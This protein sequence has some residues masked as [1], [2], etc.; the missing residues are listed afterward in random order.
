L[1]FDRLSELSLHLFASQKR[2]GLSLLIHFG[3]GRSVFENPWIKDFEIRAFFSILAGLG[4]EQTVTL[5]KLTID[6][7]EETLITEALRRELSLSPNGV[8]VKGSLDTGQRHILKALSSFL[9]GSLARRVVSFMPPTATQAIIYDRCDFSPQM[10][11]AFMCLYPHSN[12]LRYN[13]RRLESWEELDRQHEQFWFLCYGNFYSESDW[14]D[15]DDST[16]V[17]WRDFG[18]RSTWKNEFAYYWSARQIL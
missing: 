9:P 2:S 5:S 11:G 15:D 4:V 3:N 6:D 1:E 13:C 8:P 16:W 12:H 17:G 7:R 14:E 10:M 18:E